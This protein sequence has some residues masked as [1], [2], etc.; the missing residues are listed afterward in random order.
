[1]IIDHIHHMI[2]DHMMDLWGDGDL[3]ANDDEHGVDEVVE[4]MVLVK[5]SASV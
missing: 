4:A 2:Y 1:M 5:S 3:D